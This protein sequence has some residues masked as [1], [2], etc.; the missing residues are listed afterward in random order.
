MLSCVNDS[1]A[2][3]FHIF[4]PRAIVRELLSTLKKYISN[5]HRLPLHPVPLKTIFKISRKTELDLDIQPQIQLIQEQGEKKFFERGN[6][7]KFRYGDLVY[8]RELGILSLTAG[9][10][11]LS[12]PSIWA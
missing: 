8:I 10:R 5:E 1:A 9:R 2:S 11:S 6:L 4:V 3:L 7:D 12:L